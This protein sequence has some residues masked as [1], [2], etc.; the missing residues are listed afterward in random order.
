MLITIEKVLVLKQMP[1]FKTV[2]Y[3][4][5]SDLMAVSEEKTL[6]KNTVLIDGTKQNRFVYFILSGGAATEDG[7]QSFYEHE[8]V[9]LDSVFWVSMAGKTIK[10][11]ETCV[12]LKVGRDKLYRMMALHPSLATAILHELSNQIHQSGKKD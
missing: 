7:T 12:V 2:S 3:M 8:A 9:G 4:A 10:T 6:K 1:L 5:L 11:T